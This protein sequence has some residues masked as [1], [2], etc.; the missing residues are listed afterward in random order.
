MKRMIISLL[1]LGTMVTLSCTKK[2]EG[3]SGS[4]NFGGS[5]TVEPIMQST[6]DE[7]S[8]QYNSAEMAYDSV[9]SSTGVKGVLNGTYS[10]GAAS[11]ELKPGEIAAGV[12]ATP[13]ALDG[14]AVIINKNLIELSNLK[15][16][17]IALIFSGEIENWKEVGGP[18]AKIAVF[19]RDEASGT[20]DCFF[21]TVLKKSKKTFSVDCAVVTSNGD[22]VSKVAMTP[23]SIGYCGFGYIGRDPQ[24]KAIQ[25]DSITAQTENVINGTYSISRKLNIIT[26]SNI[27]IESFE[28]TFIDFLL[29]PEG[30]AII[31]EEKF[32]PINGSKED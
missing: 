27:S 6:I 9:G 8:E 32:I 5:T 2:K 3:F 22:M 18:D 10:M 20:R 11:R 17:S 21:S 15:K 1:V 25:I 29:S 24:T 16:K 14:V 7:L 13:I 19:N 4:Y 12:K 31:S 30:Q 23:Y 26:P 28:Q